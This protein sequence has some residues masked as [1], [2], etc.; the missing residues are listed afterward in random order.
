[1]KFQVSRGFVVVNLK[2]LIKAIGSTYSPTTVAQKLSPECVWKDAG[3]R[4]V[5]MEGVC[6]MVDKFGKKLAHKTESIADDMMVFEENYLSKPEPKPE[7]KPEPMPKPEVVEPEVVE[8]EVVTD[9]VPTNGYSL[10][11]TKMYG[12]HSICMYAENQNP[13]VTREQLGKAL[14]YKDPKRSISNIVT[15]QKLEGYSCLVPTITKDGKERNVVG[16]NLV[17][18]IEICS[19][20]TMKR[21]PM[22]RRWLTQAMV[23][24]QVGLVKAEMSEK[25]QGC[26][27][28]AVL[29]QVYEMGKESKEKDQIIKEKDAEIERLKKQNRDMYMMSN[30]YQTSQPKNRV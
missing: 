6:E 12:N 16:F 5:S 14:G 27:M 23:E 28:A 1:M 11:G 21:A 3:E 19:T 7:S 22:F 18:A 8:A 25:S 17:G 9:L 13:I 20:S 29:N 24:I 15:R 10:A 2:N 30:I 4:V 26:D